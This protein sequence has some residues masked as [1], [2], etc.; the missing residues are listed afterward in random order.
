MKLTRKTLS[1]M[2]NAVSIME[3]RFPGLTF[4]VKHLTCRGAILEPCREVFDGDN[5]Q[6]F[7]AI[8]VLTYADIRHLWFNTVDGG[9]VL[10]PIVLG[11]EE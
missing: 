10:E 11:G 6:W 9:L 5:E 8:D 7:L 3:A 4:E 2:D 1:A